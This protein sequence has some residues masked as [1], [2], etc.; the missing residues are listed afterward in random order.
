[1]NDKYRKKENEN[2]EMKILRLDRKKT[3]TKTKNK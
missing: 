2:K 3:T 1:M